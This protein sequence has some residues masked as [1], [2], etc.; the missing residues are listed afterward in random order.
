MGNT[1]GKEHFCEPGGTGSEFCWEKLYAKRV[2]K[3]NG[4]YNFI[5]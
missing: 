5:Y 4:N 1:L 3:K 2:E